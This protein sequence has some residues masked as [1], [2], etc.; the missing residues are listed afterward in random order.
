MAFTPRKEFYGRAKPVIGGTGS[1]P[2][3]AARL[4]CRRRVVE[5]EH[6]K[7]AGIRAAASGQ[8]HVRAFR[9]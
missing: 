3:S 4:R 2:A 7:Q 1:L 8:L 5:V 6:G 9:L